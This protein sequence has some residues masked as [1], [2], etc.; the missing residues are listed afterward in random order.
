MDFS[1]GL[2]RRA[3]QKKFPPT[4]TPDVIPIPNVT[5]HLVR[6]ITLRKRPAWWRQTAGQRTAFICRLAGPPRF[7]Q[8]KFVRWH[9]AVY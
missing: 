4:L 8:K 7:L 3:V 2:V 9:R 5:D 6:L 1:S